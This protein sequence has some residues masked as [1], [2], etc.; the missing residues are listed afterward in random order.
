MT[1][2]LPSGLVLAWYGDDFTGAAAV[3]EVLTFAGLP[4]VLFLDPPTPAQRAAFPDARAIGIAGQ[5]RAHGPGWMDAELPPVFRALHAVG[6]ALCLYKICS[7]LDSA[8]HL[9]SIGRAIDLGAAVFGGASVPVLVAAPD[10]GRY[11][12]FG[13][14]FARAGTAIHRLDRH[15][16]M[17]RHPATPMTEAD[18]ARHLSLQTD[19]RSGC[20]MLPDLRSTD[21]GDAAL[22]AAV[23]H[24]AEIVTLDCTD[25]ADL[26]AVGRLL[27]QNRAAMPLVAG[28]QGVAY[29][30]VAWF[31]ALGWLGPAAAWPPAPAVAQIAAVSGSVAATTAAQ[32]DQA[33]RGGWAVIAFEAASV[34]DPANRAAEVARATAA[35]L[36]EIG[37]GHSVIVASARGPDDP[38]V[39]RFRLALAATGIPPETAN[40]RLGAALGQVLAGIRDRSDIGRFVIA[41]GDTSGQALRQM[42]VRALTALAPTV[43][44][45]ALLHAH[46]G[47]GGF[48]L[49]LKGG[50]MGS[51]DYFDWIRAGGGLRT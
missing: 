21:G 12:A 33:Q 30:L 50:Q 3:M 44:G 6:A 20:L 24:G 49:A 22:A 2:G 46:D 29:A 42:G 14:L 26:A 43:P 1:A 13:T 48:D 17:Q 25:A 10:M 34:I 40:A 45:A 5:A 36:A 23:G 35:A 8:P 51:A 47:R 15:P 4:A 19:R 11:Q 32:I 39:A 38:G 31:R 41:G 37:A 7:T 27:W 16:V 18:V 9:G 28:S